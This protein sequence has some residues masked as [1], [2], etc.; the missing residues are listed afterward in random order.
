MVNHKTG[1]VIFP[2]VYESTTKIFML[3]I[4]FRHRNKRCDI[5]IHSVPNRMIMP[6]GYHQFLNNVYGLKHSV[7]LSVNFS[8]FSSKNEMRVNREIDTFSPSVCCT[9]SFV[10]QG[11]EVARGHAHGPIS[12]G[13]GHVRQHLRELVFEEIACFAHR[14]DGFHGIRVVVPEAVALA[15]P[16]DKTG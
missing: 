6:A 9:S 15:G 2:Q 11:G 8:K 14:Q 16:Q 7:A 5:N 1:K 10:P 3:S 12:L 13:F 4:I